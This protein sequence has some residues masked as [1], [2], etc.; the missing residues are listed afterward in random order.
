MVSWPLPL[1]GLS[2][3]YIAC[4]L[5]EF[6][7]M[8]AKY[9]TALGKKTYSSAGCPPPKKQAFAC[10][11]SGN[12]PKLARRNIC[13]PNFH[14]NSTESRK[15]QMCERNDFELR[16]LNWACATPPKI[17]HPYIPCA[18]HPLLSLYYYLKNLLSLFNSYLYNKTSL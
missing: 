9:V 12:S 14:P 16:T 10:P 15:N 18:P 1:I 17:A 8:G 4:I 3:V 6:A 11:R 7:I 13:K 2:R 5:L